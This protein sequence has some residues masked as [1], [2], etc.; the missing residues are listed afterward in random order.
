VLEFKV[1]GRLRVLVDGREVPVTDPVDRIL[2]MG[3]LVNANTVV[4][5]VEVVGSV[6]DEEPDLP[7]SAL[8]SAGRL[9]ELID[10]LPG[11]VRLQRHAN[12]YQLIVDEG[13]VDYCQAKALYL[14]AKLQTPM[15]RA[16]LL[17]D[18]FALWPEAFEPDIAWSRDVDA[19]ME[20]IVKEL[21]D[22]VRTLSKSTV[23]PDDDI[24]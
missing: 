24:Q 14:Q 17:R 12:G 9:K 21:D 1:L 11:L 16:E 6:W 22:V 5:P 18:A 3:L 8:A 2:L 23:I 10:G 4:D 20:A 15:Q 19:L 13:L 7:T